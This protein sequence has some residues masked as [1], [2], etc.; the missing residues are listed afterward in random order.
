MANIFLGFYTDFTKFS[1]A[2]EYAN[3]NT[4]DFEIF[5]KITDT[6]TEYPSAFHM[7]N[8]HPIKLTAANLSLSQTAAETNKIDMG[9]KISPSFR[10]HVAVKGTSSLAV[11]LAGWPSNVD[12]DDISITNYD[13]GLHDTVNIA[14]LKSLR[15]ATAPKR[16]IIGSGV[17]EPGG[18]LNKILNEIKRYVK[19]A[20]K[21]GITAARINPKKK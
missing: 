6:S 13:L 7:L 5:V 17:P 19:K 2:S 4:T 8:D 12:F 20:V 15:R 14:E 1:P 9:P 16:I 10:I 11:A 18:N 3:V 21:D